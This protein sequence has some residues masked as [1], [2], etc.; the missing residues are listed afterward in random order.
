MP[1]NALLDAWL[2]VIS[3]LASAGLKDDLVAGPRTILNIGSDPTSLADQYCLGRSYSFALNHRR[4]LSQ[5]ANWFR[6]AAGLNHAPAQASLGLYECGNGVKA[7]RQF[8]PA[9]RTNSVRLHRSRAA[10]LKMA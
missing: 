10:A 7:E 5:A 9:G 8:N 2:M 1:I 4:D 6:E 3:T